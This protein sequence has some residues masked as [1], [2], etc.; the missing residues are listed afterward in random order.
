MDDDKHSLSTFIPLASYDDGCPD[1]GE[2]AHRVESGAIQNDTC[3]NIN[4][5][6]ISWYRVIG[7]NDP[8][9]DNR[10]AGMSIPSHLYAP[11]RNY[12]D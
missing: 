8:L 5:F 10:G 1:D 2:R 11:A 3:S 4:G 12:F 6:G 9:T 7:N